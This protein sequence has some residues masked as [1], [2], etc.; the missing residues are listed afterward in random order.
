MRNLL[1]GPWTTVTN[2]IF[3]VLYRRR[4]STAEGCAAASTR[5]VS[6]ALAGGLLYAVY[7]SIYTAR[8]PSSN[9][10]KTS[11]NHLYSPT[12]VDN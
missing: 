2:V 11:N 10:A 1:H 12:M 4:T 6:P 9:L 7:A 5:L 8:F 3:L